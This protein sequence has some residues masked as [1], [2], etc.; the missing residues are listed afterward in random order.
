MRKLASL[1][2]LAVLLLLPGTAPGSAASAAK[3]CGGRQATI[4]GTNGNDAIQGTGRGDVIWAGGGND[5]V[6]GGSGKDTIC[7]KGG[8]D[9]LRGGSGNDRLIGGPGNDLCLGEGGTDRIRSCERGDVGG[10]TP[11]PPPPSNCDPSYPSVCIPPP[12]PD[13]DCGDIPYTNFTVVGSEPHGFDGD[14][15]GV[16]CET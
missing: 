14:G 1:V 10:G 5:R 8:R 12:P 3:S 15:N 4:T 2:S 13:L 11:P 6:R 7:G 16:G 9:I